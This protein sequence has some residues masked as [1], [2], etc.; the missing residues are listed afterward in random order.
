M[1]CRIVGAGL[2]VLTPVSVLAPV[3]ARAQ[4][5]AG[6]SGPPST[7]HL[8]VSVGSTWYEDARFR[9]AGQESSWSTNARASLGLNRSFRTG[10]FSLSGFG[11]KLYYPEIPEFD[12]WT[13]GGSAGLSWAP[14]R[15]SQLTLS[16]TYARSNT[17]QLP[18]Q[19]V[20]GLPVPTTG[21]DTA[22]SNLGFSQ[23]LSRRTSLEMSG[24]YTWRRYDESALVGGERLYASVALARALGR[25]GALTL[26]YGLSNSWI[27][28]RASRFHV[29]T[30]GA[31]RRPKRGVGLE[32]SGGVAYLEDLQQYY[33]GGSAGLSAAGRKT[34][35][36]VR[37]FRDFGLAFGYG[38]QTISDRVTAGLGWTPV[39]PL[40]FSA[41]YSYGYRQDPADE[42]FRVR[43]QVASAGF[44]WSIT[45]GLGFSA[46]YA[47]EQNQTEGFPE[48]KGGRVTASV[49]YGVDW[50]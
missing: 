20:E 19:D 44:T 47:W 24:T 2:T 17:R 10:A 8:Q 15:R 36:S 28:G 1:M 41:A 5:A 14:S 12:Q 18:E 50:R 3:R 6:L 48:V 4:T 26:A 25:S 46:R 21:V 7:W 16:Q 22:S 42:N 40:T 38:R 9:A 30:L 23:D 13:Y 11:G 33:P 39:R 27:E 45:N 34:S 32:L 49:S 29:A 35:F 37:Y 43:S 31:R